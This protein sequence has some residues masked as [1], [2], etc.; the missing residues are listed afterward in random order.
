MSPIVQR[1]GE[2]LAEKGLRLVVA[3]SC[4]G[5]LLAAAL[6]GEP[7]ASSFFEAGL[8]TYSNEAKQ[9]LLG[10]SASTLREHGAVSESAAREMVEGAFAAGG[11]AAVAI[12]GVAGPGGGTPEKPVGTV[13]IGVG[14]A[15]AVHVRRHHFGG[16]RDAVRTASVHAALDRLAELLEQAG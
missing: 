5:G 16:D 7:G 8:V 12:T 3:E 6:T 2:R 10:V 11:D 1:I 14:L 9:E 13:W 15:G 4:T